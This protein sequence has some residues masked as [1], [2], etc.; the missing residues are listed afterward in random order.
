MN[1]LT[2]TSGSPRRPFLYPQRM[3]TTP[4]LHRIKSTTTLDPP[5]DPF[6]AKPPSE[7]HTDDTSLATSSS[8]SHAGA[9]VCHAP[10]PND[11]WTFAPVMRM[12]SHPFSRRKSHHAADPPTC[13]PPNQVPPASLYTG[14]SS[15]SCIRTSAPVTVPSQRRPSEGQISDHQAHE[16]ALHSVG[17]SRYE[18][19]LRTTYSGGVRGADNVL[20][21]VVSLPAPAR[22]TMKKVC[23]AA[24]IR[25]SAITISVQ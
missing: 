4:T 24:S 17:A 12:L 7:Q 14:P 6:M 8:T 11:P 15:G 5:P 18:P 22:D 16:P 19:P 13:K 23:Q 3:R 2:H 20:R 25:S 10:V 1:P 21:P 9:Q